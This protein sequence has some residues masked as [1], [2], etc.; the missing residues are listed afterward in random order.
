MEL[1]YRWRIACTLWSCL[2][3]VCF[4]GII[5]GWGSLVFIL[6]EEGFYSEN[7]RDTSPS[8]N[9]SL[10]PG[11]VYN[12]SVI[13]IHNQSIDLSNR[14]L[15]C[16]EQEEKLNL[17]FSIAVGVMY[18]GLAIVGQLS[19]R[20]GT[21]ITRIIFTFLYSVGFLCIA[22]ATKE[23]PWLLLP[24]LS[25][26]SIGGATVFCTTLQVANL[27]TTIQT[28]IVAL[29]SGLFDVSTIMQ[30]LI[31]VAY[32]HGISRK[33]SYLFF[34]G[35]GIV[36][37]NVQ[38]FVFLPKDH[39]RRQ[40]CDSQKPAKSQRPTNETDTSKA[41]LEKEKDVS[42]ES[43]RTVVQNADDRL[44]T[45]IL[46]FG[47]ITH[48]VWMSVS[49]LLFVSFIGLLNTWL[50]TMSNDS[51][52]VSYYLDVFAYATMSTSVTAIIAG[53]AYDW[54]RNRFRGSA[55]PE[56]YFRPVCFPMA[57]CWLFG[58]LSYLLPLVFDSLY[59]V[60]PVFIMF[61]FYRSFLFAIGIAFVT[62]AFPVKYF[63]VL[64]GTIM[65]SVGASSLLQYAFFAWSKSYDS[66]FTHVNIALLTIAI[67]T[68]YQPIV[69]WIRG[70]IP[71]STPDN[72][73]NN[74]E[75]IINP[76]KSEKC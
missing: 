48:T 31:K 27:Y 65:F 23:N 73:I 42:D 67:L 15:A 50:S 40:P 74:M 17:C 43:R 49:V 6:K 2:E 1:C 54:Q 33:H 38:T 57:M 58:T 64:Y 8:S 4:A 63:G 61:T 28:T 16:D 59:V 37:F 53:F 72:D 51:K 76:P 52:I 3:V 22:F 5:Y 71:K 19:L 12:V 75:L 24:G 13:D 14:T 35:L 20:L 32:E 62:E 70:G 29:L 66:A 55:I 11:S 69:L 47:Y 25:F 39:V 68:C 60:L 41:L 9:V 10:I 46:S 7:C 45:H 18:S 30:H 21:R 56:R 36:I 44:I 26:I 34:C